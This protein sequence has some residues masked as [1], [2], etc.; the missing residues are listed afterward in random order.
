MKNNIKKIIV[1][2]LSLVSIFFTSCTDIDDLATKI[3]LEDV[4]QKDSK[5][6]EQI[7]SIANNVDNPL[8]G[9]VCLDFIYPMTL[10]TYDQ[11]LNIIATTPI[12]GDDNFS[13]FLGQLTA[14][15]TISISYPI[16][17]TLADGTVFTVNNNTELKLAIDSCSRPDIINYCNGLFSSS[18]QCVSSWKSI[19]MNNFDNK[20]VS[21]VFEPNGDGTIKLY[22]NNQIYTG[23][24]TF[25]FVNDDL[26]MN[27]NI[28]GNSQVAMDWNIDK[29]VIVDRETITIN[30]LP[31][32]YILQ[33]HCEDT[34]N[35]LIGA[36]GPA[37]GIVFYDKGSYSK[38]WRYIE[39]ST[40]DLGFFD[41][42]CVNSS[43]LESQNTGLGRGMYT[44]AA[45]VNFHDNLVGYYTNPAVCSATNNGTVL[46]K[47]A[48]QYT[49]PAF[50]TFN[51]W[52]LPSIDELQF[53]RQNLYLQNIG[54]L[55][56]AT[57]WSSNEFNVANAK[58]INFSNGNVVQLPKV[59]NSNSIK[60]RAIRYF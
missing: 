14:T 33:K 58:A 36:V 44:S 26:H 29:P 23:T 18:S 32:K 1:L 52:F 41:W 45:V 51:D 11:N 15:Q 21:A 13:D 10:F 49:N 28:Q 57:Y 24:W 7:E 2:T 38:G 40:T 48:I 22:Y 54:N 16:R 4:I 12:I 50:N 19:Y 30:K 6:F 56:N 46:S 59:V 20:Y 55:T 60:A 35:Y 47:K 37:G 53:V 31:K 5:L 17:T 42:G 27:I 43:I 34:H 9:V 3:K 8:E 25:L 39:V